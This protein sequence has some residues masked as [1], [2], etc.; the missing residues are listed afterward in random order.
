MIKH[1]FLTFFLAVTIAFST[2]LIPSAAVD[3]ST[4]DSGAE[5]AAATAESQF[6]TR[7]NNLKKLDGQY[8]TTTG[9]NCGNNSCSSC[10][11]ANVLDPQKSVFPALVD[12][13]VPDLSINRSDAEFT[14]Y[15]GN[16]KT[17]D[18]WRRGSTCCG[19]ANFAGWYLFAESPTDHVVF[20]PICDVVDFSAESV[21]ELGLMPGDILRL[22]NTKSN[23]THSVVFLSADSSGIN[24]LDCNWKFKKGD[25]YSRIS[26]H[27]IPY[28]HKDY[29][30][31]GV[32]RSCVDHNYSPEDGLCPNCGREF[33]LERNTSCAGIYEVD[34]PLVGNLFSTS[35]SP[36]TSS[37][38]TLRRSS[39][40]EII[41]QVINA[42]EELWYELIS[43]EYIPAATV[44]FC[45]KI[46]GNAYVSGAENDHWVSQG[47]TME[48]YNKWNSIIGTIRANQKITSIHSAVLDT[49][50]GELTTYGPVSVNQTSYPLYM[51]ELDTA[52]K[53]SKL[54]VGTYHLQYTVKL[55][56]G[57][58]VTLKAPKP[59][60]I[61]DPNDA[62]VH[63]WEDGLCTGCG[64]EQEIP[65]DNNVEI[66]ADGDLIFVH[67]G[68][69]QDCAYVAI[70]AYD[71]SGRMT[72]LR[73]ASGDDVSQLTLD[74]ATFTAANR[75]LL[76]FLDANFVPVK[77][78]MD[79][80][81]VP[82]T[83]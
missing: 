74:A 63:T 82:M 6:Q 73:F 21:T 8:F 45:K 14:H 47:A 75:V 11:F 24:V 33:P 79:L 19:F 15:Y 3:S 58:S 31:M 55:A 80:A 83:L 50:T 46:S 34:L 20:E 76:L 12:G 5:T 10:K 69:N 56:D 27:S 38:L 16:D 51:S 67:T 57:T 64:A 39:Q 35:E 13:F 17:Q 65:P 18:Y 40:I 32:S 81:T 1:R 7:L 37:G 68:V 66:E 41:A 61:I 42:A 25:V 26:I 59:F 72:A 71:V 22:G 48:L 28:N 52:S 49:T 36:Y 4:M 44:A 43:G 70:A 23:G 2:Q 78:S 53:F 29:H 60:T 54:P 62:H 77:D 30:Y 9:K